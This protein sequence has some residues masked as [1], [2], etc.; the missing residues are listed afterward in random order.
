MFQ[1][2]AIF[3]M[4][5]IGLF[6]IALQAK[7][8][9]VD[10]TMSIVAGLD[11]RFHTNFGR[12]MFSSVDCQVSVGW[13]VEA[14]TAYNVIQKLRFVFIELRVTVLRCTFGCLLYTT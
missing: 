13:S 14:H 9:T 4:I 6:K 1:E 5:N 12:L 2:E 8:K 10:I 3:F 11:F 7:K